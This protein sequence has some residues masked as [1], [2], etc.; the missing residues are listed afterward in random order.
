MP[1]PTGHVVV[2]AARIQPKSPEEREEMTA[3]GLLAGDGSPKPPGL[4]EGTGPS[5]ARIERRAM[6]ASAVLNEAYRLPHGRPRSHAAS[7]STSATR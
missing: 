3:L 1:V 4:S 2:N 5:A 6:K 7:A